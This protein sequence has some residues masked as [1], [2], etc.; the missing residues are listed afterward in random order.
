MMMDKHAATAS[1]FTVMFT[2]LPKYYNKEILQAK[3]DEYAD[4]MK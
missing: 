2:N 3:L 1:D 4:N